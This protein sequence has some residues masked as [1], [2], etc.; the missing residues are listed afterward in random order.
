MDRSS[1][2]VAWYRSNSASGA[3]RRRH[4]R[5]QSGAGIPA[6]ISYGNG[7][8]AAANGG[9]RQRT[10]DFLAGFPEGAAL[11]LEMMRVRSHRLHA[12]QA[13]DAFDVPVDRKIVRR[14]DDEALGDEARRR[15]NSE[16]KLRC[17]AIAYPPMSPQPDP[18]RTCLRARGRSTSTRRPP[19]L[20]EL[21]T[22]PARSAR[23]CRS[24]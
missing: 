4:C 12:V 18:I 21:G 17:R 13:H 2:S 5:G 11:H 9:A 10:R 6:R 19:R 7:G 16:L 24:C 1:I 8:C 23:R 15:L 3:A 22:E 14:P 20:N